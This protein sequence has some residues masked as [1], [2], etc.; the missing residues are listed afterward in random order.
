LARLKD[1]ASHRRLNVRRYPYA[2]FYRVADDAV[3]VLHIRHTAQKPM[4]G[5]SLGRSLSG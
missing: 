1:E 5:R 2:I 3:L 4:E